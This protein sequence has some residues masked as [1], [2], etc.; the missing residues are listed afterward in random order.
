MCRETVE[1]ARLGIFSGRIGPKSSRFDRERITSV[2]IG[3][4]VIL[5]DTSNAA[6]SSCHL[7]ESGCQI[8]RLYDG[9]LRETGNDG[10]GQEHEQRG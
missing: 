9:V 10:D 2:L 1:A 7:A 6:K 3:S 5:C 8:V 4:A